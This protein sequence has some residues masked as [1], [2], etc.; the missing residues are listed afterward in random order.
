MAPFDDFAYEKNLK[1]ALVF[2]T[3]VTVGS[4]GGD[5]LRVL[6]RYIGAGTIWIAGR[7]DS[8]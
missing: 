8:R 4:L 1:L 6:A 2:I 5:V 7:T 3:G